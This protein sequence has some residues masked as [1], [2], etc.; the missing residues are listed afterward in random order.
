MHLLILNF[1]L[2]CGVGHGGPDVSFS[3]HLKKG[4]ERYRAFDNPGALAEYAEAYR[5]AP[6]SFVTIQRMAAIYN[7]IGRILLRTDTR[8]SH[9]Y[10]KSLEFSDL[11]CAHYPEK[12]ESHFWIAL[13]QGS[14]IPFGGV[15]EKVKRAKTVLA[16]ASK[17][18]QLDSAFSP[19]YVLL[20]IFQREASNISWI[21]R[22]VARVVFAAEVSGSLPQAEDYFHKALRYDPSN[23]YAFYELYWTYKAMHDTAR[24]RQSLLSLLSLAPKNAREVEQLD[25]ARS[26]LAELAKNE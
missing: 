7:D 8:A 15:S 10:L 21:E 25:E 20:G 11:L 22:V 17:A 14:L 1:L 6:D 24:A 23:P 19:A 13:N 26:E 9:Y 3:V 18:I 12:A 2:V 4:E 16:E 5:L